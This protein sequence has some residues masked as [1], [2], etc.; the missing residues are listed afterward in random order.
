MIN[1]TE[2]IED[3][4]KRL[5]EVFGSYRQ[6]M[7]WFQL[8]WTDDIIEKHFDTYC[9]FMRGTNILLRE[10]TEVRE[11]KPYDYI[12]PPKWALERLIPNPNPE[13]LI[14]DSQLVYTLIWAFG[15][16][17]DPSGEPIHPKW[18]ACEF[19]IKNL[20][21][22]SA[23]KSEYAKYTAKLGEGQTEADREFRIEQ[24]MEDLYGEPSKVGDAIASKNAV[25]IDNRDMEIKQ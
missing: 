21:G 25:V 5:A 18:R 19:L 6:G 9:D 12:R 17:G 1:E 11:V 13:M 2:K 3:I 24:L 7:P 16:K 20:L 22:G 8:R 10:V 15:Y 23:R 14:S 4:N